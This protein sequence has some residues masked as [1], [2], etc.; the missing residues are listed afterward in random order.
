MVGQL[1]AG[2]EKSE[3]EEEETQDP[4]AVNPVEEKNVDGNNQ[5]TKDVNDPAYQEDVSKRNT[6]V[7]E[8]YLVG[9]HW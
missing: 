8:Y 7:E 9:P 6:Y 2:A 3:P 1:E 5:R 4:K